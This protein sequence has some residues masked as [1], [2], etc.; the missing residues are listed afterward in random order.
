M[1][2]YSTTR[3]LICI[4]VKGVLEKLALVQLSGDPRDPRK[5]EKA[6]RSVTSKK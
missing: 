4:T 3:G 5:T 2:V 1:V 6:Y